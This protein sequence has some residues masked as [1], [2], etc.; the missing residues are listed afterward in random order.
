MESLQMAFGEVE[1]LTR[2][3]DY[4][5]SGSGKAI[6]AMNDKKIDK[7]KQKTKT[8]NSQKYG[9]PHPAPIVRLWAT[10]RFLQACFRQLQVAVH[11]PEYSSPEDHSGCREGWQK[12]HLHI[13]H[14]EIFR[15]RLA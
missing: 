11:P 8:Y 10:R 14:R 3:I 1:S 7:Q 12:A 15:E 9:R 6:S 5:N 4:P 13:W 2:S